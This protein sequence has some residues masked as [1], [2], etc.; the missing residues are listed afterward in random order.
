MSTK[1][2]RPTRPQRS[3][4]R[5][6]LGLLLLA[7]ALPV[8]LQQVPRAIAAADDPPA[9]PRYEIKKER[10][11]YGDC[12]RFATP[13]VLSARKV[14]ESIP[15]YR[16][17]LERGLTKDDPEYWPLLRRAARIFLVALKRVCREEGFDLVGEI[18]SIRPAEDGDQD[19]ENDNGDSVPD[20]TDQVIEAAA[21]A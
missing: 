4:A 13:A 21:R 20:I 17:I 12:T 2:Q 15:A 19:D 1:R 14:Y 16:S 5:Q 9:K 11:Y 10:I 6:R 3:R 18:E 8:P 7:F